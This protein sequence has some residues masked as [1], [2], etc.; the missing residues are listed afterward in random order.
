MKIKKL[1]FTGITTLLLSLQGQALCAISAST[2][3]LNAVKVVRS[4]FRLETVREYLVNFKSLD[5]ISVDLNESISLLDQT[6][7]DLV[8]SLASLTNSETAFGSANSASFALGLL[9][10][11][12]KGLELE[13]KRNGK[14]TAT[15][16]DRLNDVYELYKELKD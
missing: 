14:L 11:D 1:I 5:P 4:I 2:Q 13:L 7:H 10:T 8:G 16:Q 6:R 9:V 15:I 3:E 12:L